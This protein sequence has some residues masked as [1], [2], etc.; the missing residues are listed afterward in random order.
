MKS[1]TMIDIEAAAGLERLRPFYKWANDN[2]HAGARG[3]LR[4]LGM[5]M[6]AGKILLGSSDIGLDEPGANSALSLAQATVALML[7]KKN[8]DRVVFARVAMGLQAE[9]AAAFAEVASGFRPKHRP[10]QRR[11]TASR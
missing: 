3:S 1:P 2:V 8:A 7:V 11:S 5:Q 4:R 10:R 6:R 9:V